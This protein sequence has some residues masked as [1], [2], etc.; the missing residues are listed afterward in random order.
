MNSKSLINH[1]LS[2]TCEKICQS[3]IISTGLSDHFMIYS[4]RKV[5][6]G[7]ID[8]HNTVKI[9]SLKQYCKEDFILKLSNMNWQDVLMC[10]VLQRLGIISRLFFTLL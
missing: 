9:R 10:L 5:V 7:Q 8:K 2:N 4:T 3:G 6:K 1:I